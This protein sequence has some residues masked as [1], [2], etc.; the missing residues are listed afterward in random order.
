MPIPSI[1]TDP[2]TRYDPSSREALVEAE[3]IDLFF[4]Q[5]PLG[6]ASALISAVALTLLLWHHVNS[7]LLVTWL[8][9]ITSV[10]A[11][12]SLLIHRYHRSGDLLEQNKTW[13]RA[14]IVGLGLCGC[15]WAAAIVLLFPSHSL[16]HQLCLAFIVCGVVTGSA[17]LYAGLPI[18]FRWFSVAPLVMLILRFLTLPDPV[19]LILASLTLL[20]LALMIMTARSFASTRR[21][22]L[23]T[24][25]ELSDRVAQRTQALETANAS[26]TNE[27]QER[28]KIEAHLRQER[29]QLEDITA[30][31]GAGLVVVSDNYEILWANKV[32]KETHAD[33]V[34][35]LCYRLQ[36]RRDTACETCGVRQVMEQG[37]EKVFHEQQ[38]ADD[39]GNP[40]QRRP[41]PGGAGTGPAHYRA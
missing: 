25:F 38:H 11:L 10:L 14:N 7:R 37:L 18:A 31:I 22:L 5:S 24:K 40:Q 15:L 2:S 30:T 4:S 9:S 26:L 41:H 23:A 27:I 20:Y 17:S 12:R 35:Q 19:H 28:R 36:Y 34:G 8:V 21:Q 32:F 39:Q 1:H 29:D 16:V 33:A 3:F 6:I 13:G